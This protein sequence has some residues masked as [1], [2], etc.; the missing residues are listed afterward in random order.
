VSKIHG[1]MDVGKRSMMNSQTALQTTGHNI[2]NKSTEGYS[3]QRVELQ[4][5]EPIGNG[6]VRIGMGS[7]TAAVTRTNNSYLEKQIGK[8][9]SSLGYFNGKSD[10]MNRVEQVYNEQAN[11]GLNTFVTDFFNSFREFANNPESLA[12]RTQ[13][14]ETA[15][16]L[17]ADFKRVNNQLKEI[18]RDLDTQIASHVDSVNQI[19]KEIAQLNDKIQL[20]TNQGGPANDERDRRD[21][22]IKQLGEKINIRW[23]EGEGGAVTITA[24]NTAVLVAGN[25]AKTL[26]VKSTPGDGKKLEGSFSIY[27]KNHDHAEPVDATKQFTGGAIGGLLDVRDNTI[28]DLLGNVDQMAYSIATT[29][30]ELHSRGYD[31]YNRQGSNFFQA[32]DDVRGAAANLQI[33]SVISRDPNR[34]AGAKNPN[35]P[36]DNTVANA[37]SQLQFERV[38][39]DKNTTAD[40]FY[41]SM[42]GEVGI[43]ARKANLSQESQKGIVDNLKNIR[44]S[45]SGVSLDEETT[46]LIEYQKAFDASARL[47]KT[48][49]E[50]FDTVLN[51]KRM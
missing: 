37:I 30:N 41:N 6:N 33:S 24:G 12:T 50:M 17:T 22:L 23:A 39:P 26:E 43:E 34:I 35:A 18:G 5:A 11:K 29:V 15:E 45:I 25:D 13:V 47:I 28:T 42:V 31:A 7:K 20:V 3:R 46:K 51:L 16:F 48:A 1:M 40:E 8:E 38:M 27:Y 49:D 44:E 36:G 4:T 10:A 21:L 32:P 2:A 19:T 14:K 9:Q